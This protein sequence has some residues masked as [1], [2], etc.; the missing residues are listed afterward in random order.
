MFEV[1]IVGGLIVFGA[2][3]ALLSGEGLIFGGALLT[4]LGFVVGVPAAFVYH[5]K[6]YA[7]LKRAGVVPARWWISPMKHHEAAGERA[8]EGFAWAFRLGAAGF[9]VIVLGC[10]LAAIGLWKLRVQ[11]DA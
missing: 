8:E 1:S 6:L 4:A 11:G 9:V 10:L 2:I 3:V 5:A 7:A